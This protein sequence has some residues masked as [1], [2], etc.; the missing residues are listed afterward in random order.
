MT[1]AGKRYW[2]WVA[3]F[4]DGNAYG[5]AEVS[6]TEPLTHGEQ[7]ISLQTVLARDAGFS[8]VV[9]TTWTLLRV[10]DVSPQVAAALR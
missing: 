5:A 10:E 2:Y 8:K 9:I 1:V 3:Y 4:A 7:V 6:M